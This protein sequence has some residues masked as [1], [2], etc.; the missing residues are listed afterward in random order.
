MRDNIYFLFP[1][2]RFFAFYVTKNKYNQT[3]VLLWFNPNTRCLKYTAAGILF[4]YRQEALHFLMASQGI[5]AADLLVFSLPQGVI[6]KE[7][8][9]GGIAFQQEFRNL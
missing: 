4:F 3:G 2:C 8:D 5:L 7:L 6:C 9:A 1:N